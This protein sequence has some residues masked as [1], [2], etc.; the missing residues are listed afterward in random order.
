VI[1][2][3]Y[4]KAVIRVFKKLNVEVIVLRVIQ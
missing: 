2:K 1:E 4:K 3:V